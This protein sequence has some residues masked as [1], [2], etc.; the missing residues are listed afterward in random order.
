MSAIN[1]GKVVTGGLIAGL[2][3]N[4]LDMI[5][6]MFIMAADFQANA[7]RLGLDP[8]MAESAAGITT[9]VV[10]D[11]LMGILAVWVY[12]AIRPRFGPGPK[13]AVNAAIALWLAVSLV[14]FG[15][16]TGGL[17][18]LALFVKITLIQLVFSIVGTVAGAK[19]YSE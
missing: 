9:W 12:A 5:N 11:F 3:F 17:F 13:T 6:G 4:V 2:V 15:L 7:V 8:A 1:T 18:P 14:M 10:V 16:T 19:F